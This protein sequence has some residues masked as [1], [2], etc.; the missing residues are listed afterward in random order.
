MTTEMVVKKFLDR[1]P[2]H[3]RSVAT[4]GQYLLSYGVRV[5]EWTPRDVVVV[6]PVY[7]SKTT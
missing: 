7:Y 5:A 6:S 4:D 1:R 2:G 3:G